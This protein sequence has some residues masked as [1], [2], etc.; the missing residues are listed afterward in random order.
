MFV[1]RSGVL[2]SGVNHKNP[3]HRKQF[4]FVLIYIFLIRQP[5]S[6]LQTI[7]QSA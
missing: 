2:A 4:E 5:K 6:L 3:Q 1:N 7:K